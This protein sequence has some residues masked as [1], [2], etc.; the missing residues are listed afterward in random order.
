[1]DSRKQDFSTVGRALLF[2]L[3]VAG[4][5]WSA[6]SFVPWYYLSGNYKKMKPGQKQAEL[7]PSGTYR[8]IGNLENLVTDYDGMKT[9]NE[10]FA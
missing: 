5:L 1:M 9:M 2:T 6:V 10:V 4:W 3:N 7:T 8:C